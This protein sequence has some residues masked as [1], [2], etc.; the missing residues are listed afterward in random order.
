MSTTRNT[1]ALKILIGILFLLLLGL[2]A[3]T[4]KFYNELTANKT[5][6]SEEKAILRDELNDL[7]INYNTELETNQVLTSELQEA[8][9]RIQNLLLRL[10]SAE[11]SQATL[12]NYRRELSILRQ[13]RD[14]LRKKTDSLMRENAL[15]ASQKSDVEAAFDQTVVQRDS[16]EQQ[17]RALQDDLAKGAQLSVSKFKAEGVIMRRSGKT[18]PNDRVSRIDKLEICYTVNANALAKPGAHDFYIQVIDPRNNVI[19]EHV[20][21]EFGENILIYSAYQE[22]NYAN[23]EINSCVYINPAREEFL[24]GIYRINLFENDRLL[25]NSVL[26]LE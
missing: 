2:G 21:L 16:L 4:Y 20:S 23:Q 19:G 24:P 1:N 18:V 9:N 10:E 6:L 25:S 3:Y 17:N 5:A 12:Q 14:A 15:L 7:L 26:E 22:I 13:E 11:S 8:R